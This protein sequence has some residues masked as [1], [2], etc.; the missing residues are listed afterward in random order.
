MF[1]DQKISLTDDIPSKEEVRSIYDIDI[2]HHKLRFSILDTAKTLADSKS[3]N[4]LAYQVLL[5][6]SDIPNPL[7]Y[8]GEIFS[9]LALDL[10]KEMGAFGDLIRA[11]SKWK[12]FHSVETSVNDIMVSKVKL[13]VPI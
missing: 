6:Y 5:E 12:E 2:E 10:E 11:F 4:P 1:L 9:R 8:D 13:N 3:P 7:E